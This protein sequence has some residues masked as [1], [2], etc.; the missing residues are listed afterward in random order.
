M[1]TCDIFHF[2]T[3]A[4]NL[5]QRIHPNTIAL[6]YSKTEIA[7]MVSAY[8]TSISSSSSNTTILT[9][10]NNT[11]ISTCD[12]NYGDKDSLQ[13][14]LDFV[15]LQICKIAKL[16]GNDKQGPGSSICNPIVIE[17]WSQIAI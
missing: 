1:N 3:Q 14:I 5:A 11:A 2:E 13:D 4:S 6:T 8:N 7:T 15:N 17:D 16:I 12:E 10:S 9:T